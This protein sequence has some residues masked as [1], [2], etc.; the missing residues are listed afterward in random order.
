MRNAITRRAKFDENDH[1]T[2]EG[3]ATYQKGDHGKFFRIVCRLGLHIV[4]DRPR[5][6][7]GFRMSNYDNCVD[8]GARLKWFNVNQ[9]RYG[10]YSKDPS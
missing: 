1:C 7:D 9:H 5:I 2:R 3:W 8:C 4:P 6:P 10:G